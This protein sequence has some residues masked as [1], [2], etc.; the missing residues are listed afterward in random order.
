MCIRDSTNK[1]MHKQNKH[2]NT[3]RKTK[4]HRRSLKEAKP[5]RKPTNPATTKDTNKNNLPSDRSKTCR[6]QISTKLRSL[7]G[8]KWNSQKP[9]TTKRKNGHEWNRMKMVSDFEIEPEN[10]SLSFAWPFQNCFKFVTKQNPKSIKSSLFHFRD[11]GITWCRWPFWSS[12]MIRSG[13]QSARYG[14]K[15]NP[16]GPNCYSHASDC[17]VQQ[18]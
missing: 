3:Q 6:N 5:R 13:S 17:I 15:V 18:K 1:K 14:V 9:T 11:H 12:F 7:Y 4:N 8:H 2:H 10:G 16:R